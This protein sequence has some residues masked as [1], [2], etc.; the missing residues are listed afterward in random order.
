M[1]KSDSLFRSGPS[2]QGKCPVIP[3][4][5]S[6]GAC[7]LQPQSF[8]PSVHSPDPSQSGL[9]SSGL[10]NFSDTVVSTVTTFISHRGTPIQGHA[11]P[12]DVAGACGRTQVKALPFLQRKR[13]L[14]VGR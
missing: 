7:S 3:G 14:S 2:A 6:P 8:H 9:L 1:M 5:C 11:L 4:F 13:G 12:E 10:G